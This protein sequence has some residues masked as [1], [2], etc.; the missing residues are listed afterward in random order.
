M[1]E[2]MNMQPFLDAQPTRSTGYQRDME[3]LTMAIQGRLFPLEDIFTMKA[4]TPYYWLVERIKMV[5]DIEALFPEVKQ[6][7]RDKAAGVLH[8]TIGIK[9]PEFKS[10]GNAAEDESLKRLLAR[11]AQE[12]AED[13]ERIRAFRHAA[14]HPQIPAPGQRGNYIPGTI[15]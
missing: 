3:E 4:G 2:P 5:E 15:R 13:L 12:D 9:T 10:T 11:K 6:A 7:L 14:L 1:A 8:D